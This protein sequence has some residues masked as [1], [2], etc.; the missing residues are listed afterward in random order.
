MRTFVLHRNEKN[1]NS[2]LLDTA[3]T[4]HPTHE[5]FDND[6]EITLVGRIG[7]PF[8]SRVGIGKGF[9]RTRYDRHVVANGNVTSGSLVAKLL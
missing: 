9:L 3:T 2:S 1:T 5:R 6:R 4:T 7:N 8:A